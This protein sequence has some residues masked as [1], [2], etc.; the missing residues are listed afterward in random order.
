MDAVTML[1]SEVGDRIPMSWEEYEALG[2]NV[3][4]EYIDGAL[5][6][7]PSPTLPHQ[8]TCRRLANLLEEVLP[9][10]VR[11]S[12]AWAWKPR[13]DELIPDVMVFDDNG[14]VKR[15]TGTPHL[16]V[17]VLSTDRAA[18]FVRK[19]AKYAEA[20][21]RRYWIIDPEGPEVVVYERG[22]SGVFVETGRYRADQHADL[23]L[24]VGRVSFRPADLL[25]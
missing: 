9:A 14:E 5:L 22:D 21:V 16:V 23:D 20:G 7:S 1:T 3:R 18:D 4:G 8:E 12:I 2:E 19:F 10:G 11:V 15:Y 17:E 6:V 13:S 25:R 24:G